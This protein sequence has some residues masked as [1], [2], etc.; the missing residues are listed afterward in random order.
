MCIDGFTTAFSC[1][2]Q[3]FSAPGDA[4]TSSEV[5]RMSLFPCGSFLLLHLTPHSH[6]YCSHRLVRGC[7]GGKTLRRPPSLADTSSRTSISAMIGFSCLR[8]SEREGLFMP[9]EG[10]YV[11]ILTMLTA[12]CLNRGP[13]RCHDPDNPIR[14]R[15]ES[16]P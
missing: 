6:V 9:C 1:R 3:I 7:A 5:L 15:L 13:E 2:I 14:L 12:L 4:L 10:Y 8:V 16:D 11:K